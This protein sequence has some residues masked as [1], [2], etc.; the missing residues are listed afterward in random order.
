MRESG[1]TLVYCTVA[2]V[3]RSRSAATHGPMTSACPISKI[4]VCKAC[5][6]RGADARRIS[7]GTRRQSARWAIVEGLL[8]RGKHVFLPIFNEACPK[9]RLLEQKRQ[10]SQI[11]GS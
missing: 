11:G 9:V 8:I 4:S 5:S 2:T 10:A 6:K 7:T 3:T 1:G